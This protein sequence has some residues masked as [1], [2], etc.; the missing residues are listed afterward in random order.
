M[1]FEVVR[2]STELTR[3]G[4]QLQDMQLAMRELAAATRRELA[5][6]VAR[7]TPTPAR[8][9]RERRT[10]FFF[11]REQITVKM[12][13]LPALHHS[14]QRCCA[15]ATQTDNYVALLRMSDGDE[16]P[17]GFVALAIEYVAPAPGTTDITSSLL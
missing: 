7:A 5:L 15:I 9:C 1:E 8:R 16:D 6:D 2:L 13:V 17:D 3:H 12:A 10:R 4:Q 11:R 14:A